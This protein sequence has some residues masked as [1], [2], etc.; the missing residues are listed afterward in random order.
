MTNIANEKNPNRL[1][2]ETSP[3]LLQHAHNPVDWFPWGEEA[4]KQAKEKNKPHSFVGWVFGL[5]LVPCDGA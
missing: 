5:S 1:I 4:L 3:Y 2:H